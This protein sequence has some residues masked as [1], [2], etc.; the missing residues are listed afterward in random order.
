MAA[1]F[2]LEDLLAAL[3]GE[4]PAIDLTGFATAEQWAERL[5][6]SIPRMQRLI[7]DT[8]A[9]R[10]CEHRKVPMSD[11]GLFSIDGSNRRTNAYAFRVQPQQHLPG[12]GH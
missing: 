7:R 3:R 9:K 6:C 10:L 2:T 12:E 4:T 8:L 1:T 5:G 11:M